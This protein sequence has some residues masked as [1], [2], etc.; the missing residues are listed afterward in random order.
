VSTEF[1][2]FHT[3]L[4]FLGTPEQTAERGAWIKQVLAAEGR[5]EEVEQPLLALGLPKTL[6]ERVNWWNTWPCFDCDFDEH[7]LAQ[8]RL[9]M[10]SYEDG[11]L[12]AVAAIVQ[13][14]I[15]KFEPRRIWTMAWAVTSTG[16]SSC[17]EFGG[18]AMAVS[19]D[20]VL[21]VPTDVLARDL[22]D[23]LAAWMH[24]SSFVETSP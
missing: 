17:N 2:Q 8:G 3:D 23:K 1:L 5:Y 24:P 12:F 9:K 10:R 19:R 4:W 15:R 11:D 7:D 14:Y 16:A 6:L 18:G 21:M 22:E 20:N 13:G